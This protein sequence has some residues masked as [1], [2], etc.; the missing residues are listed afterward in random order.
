MTASPRKAL[1]DHNLRAR[2]G[3]CHIQFTHEM[4]PIRPIGLVGFITNV[5]TRPSIAHKIGGLEDRSCR[6]IASEFL[7]AAAARS[8]FVGSHGE[9]AQAHPTTYFAK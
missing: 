7:T 2:E 1:Q 6:G 3:R 5:N 9:G 4:E 8:K